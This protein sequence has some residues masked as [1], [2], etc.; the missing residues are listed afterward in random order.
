MLSE[1]VEVETTKDVL[2]STSELE[3][4]ELELLDVGTGGML[5]VALLEVDPVAVV[6]SELTL[7]EVDETLCPLLVVLLKVLE[8]KSLPILDNPLLGVDDGEGSKLGLLLLD[9]DEKALEVVE[10]LLEVTERVLTRFVL[11]ELAKAE[12]ETLWVKLLLIGVA[13]EDL[14]TGSGLLDIDEDVAVKIELLLNVDRASVGAPLLPTELILDA[15]DEATAAETVDD[16]NV[17]PETV[18]SKEVE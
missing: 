16:E 6:L 4:I 5:G 12:E 9:A 11:L 3:F 7:D 1:V 10:P 14:A 13:D 8:A 18:D 2:L 15:D 17:D